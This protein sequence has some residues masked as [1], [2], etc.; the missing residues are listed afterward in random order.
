MVTLFEAIDN[1]IDLNRR[2]NRVLE[3][4]ARAAFKSWFVDFD[5]V[6][7][8]MEGGDPGLPPSLAA[9]LPDSLE[10]SRV[11]LVPSGWKV[12]E[13]GDE[14]RVIGGSTPSTANPSY[15]G[16]DIAFATPKDLSDLS[17]PV[18]LRTA[19]RISEVGAAEPSVPGFC[20]PGPCSCRPER[21]SA[22]WPSLKCRFV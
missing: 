16:G 2:M 7:K 14:V 12:G 3:S 18:V 5:P 20:H 22:T 11:G 9:L 6:R 17:S 4:I 19:R 10:E 15:W 1:K 21:R 8:K 13:I